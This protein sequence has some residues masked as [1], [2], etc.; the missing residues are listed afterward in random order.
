M[1]CWTRLASGLTASANREPLSALSIVSCKWASERRRVARGRRNANSAFHQMVVCE[2]VHA[3]AVVL[4]SS[5]SGTRIPLASTIETVQQ[6][7]TSSAPLAQAVAS[8]SGWKFA[9]DTE[10]SAWPSRVTFEW[11]SFEENL[12]SLSSRERD[13]QSLVMR[14]TRSVSRSLRDSLAARLPSSRKSSSVTKWSLRSS[15]P[16][17]TAPSSTASAVA[18]TA[19]MITSMAASN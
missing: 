16:V 15:A 7:C 13:R 10:R 8:A 18:C 9:P 17:A 1:L 12:E 11:M 6:T 19:P 2:R 4:C 3:T 14:L 5:T